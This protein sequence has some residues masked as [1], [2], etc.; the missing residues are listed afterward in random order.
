M[1]LSKNERKFLEMYQRLRNRPPTLLRQLTRSAPSYA[2]LL[3]AFWA[4][5]AFWL[6]LDQSFHAWFLWG[7]GCGVVIRDLT[8]LIKPIRLWPVLSTVLDWNKIDKLLAED[9]QA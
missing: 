4:M 3:I 1:P 8:L 7:I 9:P 2:V 6:A 5:S